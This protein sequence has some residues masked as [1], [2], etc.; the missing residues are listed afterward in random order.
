[1]TEYLD[2]ACIDLKGFT[3]DFYRSMTEGTLAPVLDTL[4]TLK[5]K[6]THVEIVN[7][8]IPTKNDD[9]DQVREMAIWIRDHL[10]SDV[11]LHFT[12]FY[13]LYKLR[14]LPPTP[15]QTLEAARRIALSLGL[16]YVYVG[17]VPGHEGEHTY[18]PRCKKL[19]I[20][21]MGYSIP[22]IHLN[23]GQCEY[24]GKPIPGIWA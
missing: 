17:N 18:C 23:D 10:G 20:R 21:R 12:K 22:E 7:L 14:N 24:C 2:A 15:V 4:E 6:G 9:M 11:P 16:E 3:E 1:L 5:R 8:M 13:P 19:L